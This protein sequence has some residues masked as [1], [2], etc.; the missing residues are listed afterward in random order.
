MLPRARWVDGA[1]SLVRSPDHSRVDAVTASTAPPGLVSTVAINGTHY[2]D[3]GVR[4][5]GNAD[6]ASGYANVVVLSPLGGR[7]HAPEAGQF[8]VIAPDRHPG[9]RAKRPTSPV[10][11]RADGQR[12]PTPTRRAADRADHGDAPDPH[13]L[14]T[15]L[16]GDYAL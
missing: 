10:S 16:V 3:G 14:G 5:P 1:P 4:S 6:L 13:H 11:G 7:S 9:S 15:R 8:E 2:I 12:L